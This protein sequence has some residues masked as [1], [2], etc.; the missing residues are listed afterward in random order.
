MQ[1]PPYTLGP[2]GAVAGAQPGR[3][4]T[5]GNVPTERTVVAVGVVQQHV[6][7]ARV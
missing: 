4:C 6:Q 3:N 1:V 7:D 5:S 2:G